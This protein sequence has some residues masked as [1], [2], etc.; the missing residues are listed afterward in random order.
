MRLDVE[1]SAFLA[2]LDR[3]NLEVQGLTLPS[4]QDLAIAVAAAEFIVKAGA[5]NQHLTL[6]ELVVVDAARTFLALVDNPADGELWASLLAL[7]SMFP[8]DSDE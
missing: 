4:V 3:L 7:K 1:G 2:A 5:P 6:P 8:G